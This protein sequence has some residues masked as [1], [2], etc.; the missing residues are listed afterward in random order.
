MERYLAEFPRDSYRVHD[1]PGIGRFYLDDIDDSI[2]KVLRRGEP[3]EPHVVKLLSRLVRPGTNAI[4]VGAH[5]GTLTVPLAQLVGDKGRVYA[6]EPQKKIY[7]ELCHNLALNDVDNVVPIRCALGARSG[8]IEM[9]AADPANEGGTAIGAGGDRAEIRTL[10]SFAI[11]DVSLLKI[12]VELQEDAVLAGALE[13]IRASRPAIVIEIMGGHDVD[14]APEPIRARARATIARLESL[15]YTVER[16]A[17][18][19]YLALPR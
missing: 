6:F 5:I 1:V 12:D 17:T 3:W 7:R 19:D 14:S 15:G 4:D 10:D 13:T 8:T 11:S 2:K 18:W 16:I 9:D